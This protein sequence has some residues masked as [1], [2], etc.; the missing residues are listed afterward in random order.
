MDQATKPVARV[1]GVDLHAPG[2]DVP[3]DELRQRAC[4]ELMRQAAIRDRLLPADDPAPVAGAISQAA[5]DAID[6][7]LDTALKVPEPSEEA[8]R[9]HHAATASRWR[10]GERARLRHILFAVTPGVDVAALRQ[11]AEACLLD[12]RCHDGQAAEVFAQ[13]ARELSNC[14]TGADGGELGWVAPADAAPEMSRELFGSAE[15]GVLPRLVHSR[16]GFHV[17]EV[18]ER[19]AGTDRPFD[20]V[21]G[22]VVLSLKQRAW[23]TAL[24]QLLQV[25][26]GAAAIEG[27]ALDEAASP[28]VQ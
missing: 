16:F 4:T 24:R 28:L 6:R 1:N 9:R 5:A 27:V 2:E 26:A 18:L 12:V 11:R 17:V 13:A 23:V 20:E 15:I 3:P 7:W 14:P 10:T 21:R 19:D 8:C 25:L 22:A